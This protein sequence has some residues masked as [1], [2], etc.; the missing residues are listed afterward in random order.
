[1]RGSRT[2]AA[3]ALAL[4][5]A[6]AAQERAPEELLGRWPPTARGGLDDARIAAGIRE[7]LQAATE[8]A[9]RLAG[10]HDGYNGNP[11]IRIALPERLGPVARGARAVGQGADVDRFVRAM[12]RAAERAGAGRPAAR[13]A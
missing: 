4:T 5:A 3:L 11:A 13:G 2:A 12:N 10:A 6:A 7:A 8:A 1:M 9:S